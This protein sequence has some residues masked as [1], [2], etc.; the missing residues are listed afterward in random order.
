M[1][2]G[3][4]KEDVRMLEDKVAAAEAEKTQIASKQPTTV[5]MAMPDNPLKIKVLSGNGKM[6]SAKNMASR[7]KTIGYNVE[8]T[9]LAPSTAFP[10]DIIFHSREYAEQAKALADQLGPST[11]LKPLTWKSVFNMI[12]VTRNEKLD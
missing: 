10:A 4:L 1:Q 5:A 7:L 12:I 3:A 11:V 8:R 6:T 9:D 2:I